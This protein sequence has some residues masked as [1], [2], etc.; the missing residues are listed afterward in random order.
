[1]R[2]GCVVLAVRAVPHDYVQ[3]LIRPITLTGGRAVTLSIASQDLDIIVA[4]NM[5]VY[6]NSFE[7]A[8][9]LANVS[10]MLRPVGYFLTIYA[11]AA[12]P[13]LEPSVSIISS[14]FFDRHNRTATP[15]SAT[16]VAD[17]DA[18]SAV[19]SGRQLPFR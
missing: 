1:M 8:L 6:Y 7:Q 11:L 13:P 14:V 5:L 9:A 16:G 18:L 12:A 2:R 15:C 4:T 19:V 10:K 17:R 3:W